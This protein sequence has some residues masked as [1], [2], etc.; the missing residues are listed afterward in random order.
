[1]IAACRANA[2]ELDIQEI[3]PKRLDAQWTEGLDEMLKNPPADKEYFLIDLILN[4]LPLRV[5]ET[6]YSER[7]E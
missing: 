5:R 4:R 1:M 6:A 3:P 7:F 2:A